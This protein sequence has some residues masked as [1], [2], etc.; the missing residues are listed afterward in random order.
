MYGVALISSTKFPS[1]LQ[2]TVPL[3]IETRSCGFTS[4]ELT[5]E[6][7]STLVPFFSESRSTILNSSKSQSSFNPK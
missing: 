6:S 7:M 5:K 4:I 2:C 1:P 3:G